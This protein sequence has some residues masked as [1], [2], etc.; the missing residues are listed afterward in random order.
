MKNIFCNALSA[1]IFFLFANIPY[2]RSWHYL[3]TK[4]SI[5]LRRQVRLDVLWSGHFWSAC[6]PSWLTDGLT[7]IMIY[8]MYPS[9]EISTKYLLYRT[10]WSYQRAANVSTATRLIFLQT[11]LLWVIL[12]NSQLLF[13]RYVSLKDINKYFGEAYFVSQVDFSACLPDMALLAFILLS[14]FRPGFWLSY[15]L[16]EYYNNAVSIELKEISYCRLL[17]Y[18]IGSNL[19]LVTFL[20]F[21]RKLQ[22]FSVW[23]IF[24]YISSL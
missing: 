9:A 15:F 21:D 13:P 14:R 4:A 12:W 11:L 23:K 17:I 24:L 20:H 5:A 7:Y 2:S 19:A 8:L 3:Q 18:S 1:S 16:E 6:S 22:A 10:F